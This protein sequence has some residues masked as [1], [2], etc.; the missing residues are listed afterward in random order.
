MNGQPG[1]KLNRLL[2]A[3]PSGT[4]AVQRWLSAQGIS[5]QLA[6]RYC[7][8]G[9]LERVARGVYVRAGEAVTWEGAVY[10]LQRQLGMSIHPGAKTALEMR[11][12]AH[13]LAL[14]SR[15]PVTLFGVPRE[16]LPG[17]FRGRDWG[18]S[19]SY[20]TSGLFAEPFLGLAEHD[21]GSFA[22]SV[23]TPERAALELL[24][25]VPRRQSYEEARLLFAGLTTLRARL[26]QE[27]LE[28]CRS[29]KVRRLFLHLAERCDLPWVARLDP[30]RIDL[31]RGKRV[32]T[33]GG[34]LD[35]RY[36]ITVPRT[37]GDSPG[38]G[39]P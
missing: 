9:W 22:L 20:T 17:W 34:R 37:E 3:W 35:A 27:L 39:E 29:V 32:I 36:Q 16:R 31:G 19:V 2:R 14:G 4:L 23:S 21:V 24:H 28:A 1:T 33:P 6:D 10:A 18:T 30:S 13:F 15:H 26:V 7:R 8:S 12:L 38:M 11:G 25:L 5:R